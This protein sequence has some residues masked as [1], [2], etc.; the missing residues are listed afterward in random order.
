[1]LNIYRRKDGNGLAYIL[2]KK[3]RKQKARYN[4]MNFKDLCCEFKD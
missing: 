1:M 4:K 2:K 3:S